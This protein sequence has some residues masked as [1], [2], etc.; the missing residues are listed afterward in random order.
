MEDDKYWVRTCIIDGCFNLAKPLSEYCSKCYKEM[1]E[2]IAAKEKS[3]SKS[4][5]VLDTI[6]TIG[7]IIEEVIS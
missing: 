6:F 3:T 5:F 7:L 1:S 2:K 4:D